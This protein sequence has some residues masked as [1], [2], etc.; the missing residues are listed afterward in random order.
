MELDEF[1]SQ[2]NNKLATDHSGRSDADFA[3]LLNKKTFSFIDKLKKSL[4]FEIYTCIIVIV[5]FFI[6]F[7]VS[8]F[9]SI[10]IYFAVFTVL[11]IA[12]LGVLIYLLKRINQLSAT[13]LPIKSNLQTI[14]KIIE[15]FI[16]RYF[17][18]TMALIPVCF[19]FAFYLGFNEKQSIPQL[20][21]TNRIFNTPF[22]IIVFAMLYMLALAV[23]IYYFTKWYIRKLYGKYLIQLKAC[24]AELSE[25]AGD[26]ELL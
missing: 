16:K 21:H 3:A 14:V 2:L 15:T 9:S 18:F 25:D 11:S 20:E 22:K 19:V 5:S 7:L 10:R 12:F 23:G 17:Q 13:L 4:W 8:G 24:I 6:I 26:R 1:K